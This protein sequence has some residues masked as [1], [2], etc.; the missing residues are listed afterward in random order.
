MRASEL[1][2]SE[3]VDGTG[4]RLGPVRDIRVTRDGF[5]VV[6]LVVGGGPFASIAHDWGYAYGR[7]NGPWLLRALTR[8]ATRR[9]RFV[10]V[11]RIADW[12]PGVV[13]ISGEAD[14]LPALAEILH[15]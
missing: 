12:G 9:A 8:P 2:A 1:L 13:T 7:A 15:R 14:D 4:R 10:P 5:R 11:E 6:G 3:L